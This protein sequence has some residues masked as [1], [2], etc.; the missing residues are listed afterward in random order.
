M[1]RSSGLFLMHKCVISFAAV[2]LNT[3]YEHK[4]IY[5]KSSGAHH[6]C[7]HESY[8]IHLSQLN[9]PF[10]SGHPRSASRNELELAIPGEGQSFIQPAQL[11]QKSEPRID[12]VRANQ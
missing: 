11:G 4:S 7:K 3:G 1:R 9:W 8:I 10:S 6:F 2:G 12:S 5:L